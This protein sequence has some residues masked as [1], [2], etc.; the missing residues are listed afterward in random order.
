[1]T[2]PEPY[3]PY[4]ESDTHVPRSTDITDQLDT[5]GLGGPSRLQD[6]A[7]IV[8]EDR[9]RT[10]VEASE[11][12]RGDGR[13]SSGVQSVILPGDNN[14]LIVDKDRRE[15]AVQQ[16]HDR[17]DEAREAGAQTPA[18]IQADRFAAGAAPAGGDPTRPVEGAE[19]RRS[20]RRRDSSA[21]TTPATTTGEVSD[22]SP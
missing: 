6:I 9:R 17:A 5:T 12:L 14:E 10:A 21:V 20:G 1:M 18:E 22:T 16:I 3:E 8:E 11:A 4:R 7:P 13:H 19:V 15:S 2:D